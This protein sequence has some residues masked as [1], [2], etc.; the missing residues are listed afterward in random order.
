MK[1]I[2]M[3]WMLMMVI[4]LTVLIGSVFVANSIFL[5][6]YYIH[7]TEAVL[8]EEYEIIKEFNDMGFDEFVEEMDYISEVMSFKYTVVDEKLR[9]LYSTGSMPPG[10]MPPGPKGQP[11]APL[12]KFQREY[13]ASKIE[14]LKQG[15]TFYAPLKR[16]LGKEEDVVFIG[17]FRAGV[18]L[19]ISQPIEQ[20]TANA[21][22]ANDFLLIIGSA[23]L[24]VAVLVTYF[25]SKRMVK[26]ILEITE[27][28]SK[29]AELDFSTRYQGTSKDEVNTLGESINSISEKL[30]STINNLEETNAHLQNEM[31]LQKR[32]LASVSHEFKTPVGLIRGYSES[33]KLGMAQ[34]AEEAEEFSDIIINEADR[35]NRLINDIILSMH[36]ESESFHMKMVDFNLSEAIKHVAE[37]FSKVSKD[38]HFELLVAVPDTLT[39]HGDEG[40]IVQVL[41][42]LISNGIRHVE[43][44]GVIKISAQQNEKEA[45]IEI[46]N[47]GDP[48][49]DEHLTRLFDAFYSVQDSR[50]RKGTGSGLGLSIIHGIIKKHKGQCGVFNAENGVVFWFT[51]PI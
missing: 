7:K 50:N 39:I 3:K 49:P 36:M 21:T 37:R 30:D 40:R 10:S 24:A 48:I 6:K 2:T 29:I 51:L 8:A 12:P 28:T 41:D 18:Y 9:V 4:I 22:V 38:Q 17:E 20:I 47:T 44:E 43:D 16:D 26:P 46:F 19:M 27:I 15:K 11:P 1:S 32:F 42:N 23:L 33:L 31:K 34:S 13:L 35:L 5:E 45:R 25:A 14:E